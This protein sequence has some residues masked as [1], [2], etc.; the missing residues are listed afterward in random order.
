M[1]AIL[2][3]LAIARCA[4]LAGCS[5]PLLT[6]AARAAVRYLGRGK[7]TAALPNKKTVECQPTA[8]SGRTHARATSHNQ[9]RIR[10]VNFHERKWVRFRER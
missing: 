10:R 4:W 9:P 6:D 7:E 8:D 3:M 2:A 1:L 5:A